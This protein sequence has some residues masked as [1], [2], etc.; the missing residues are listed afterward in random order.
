MPAAYSENLAVNNAVDVVERLVPKTPWRPGN[1]APDEDNL[2]LLSG[3]R[4]NN[5][6]V[7]L[8]EPCAVGRQIG[9]GICGR[10]GY[11]VDPRSREA[12]DAVMAAEETAEGSTRR[13]RGRR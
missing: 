12:I 4:C 3:L 9:C 2:V 11:W 1:A 6:G 5:C 8:P 7:D 10:G 13:R